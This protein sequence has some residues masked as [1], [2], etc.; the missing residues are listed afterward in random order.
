MP[1]R[2]EFRVT[3]HSPVH[4]RDTLRQNWDTLIRLGTHVSWNSEEVDVAD[5]QILPRPQNSIKQSPIKWY[6]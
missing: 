2:L 6:N 3:V 1:R 5:G 4:A